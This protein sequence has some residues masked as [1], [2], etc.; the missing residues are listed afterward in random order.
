MCVFSPKDQ[1][2][3][4]PEWM[5]AKPEQ[6]GQLLLCY[7][8]VLDTLAQEVTFRTL[9]V[10]KA[11]ICK[12]HDNVPR[13][14]RNQSRIYFGKQSKVAIDQTTKKKKKKDLWPIPVKDFKL[15]MVA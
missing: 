4:V 10:I 14:P 1:T 8:I 5:S 12:S 7:L 6:P 11:S 9:S 13:S 3:L 15:L 2:C